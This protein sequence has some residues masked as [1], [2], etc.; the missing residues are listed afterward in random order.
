MKK[1]KPGYFKTI[2]T[3]YGSLPHW[4]LM[5]TR[6][7][8]VNGW[9]WASYCYDRVFPFEVYLPSGVADSST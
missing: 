3:K 9:V 2:P 1:Y 7:R 5:V 4:A 6:H 8:P